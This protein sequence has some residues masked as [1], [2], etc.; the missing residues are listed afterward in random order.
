MT[1]WSIEFLSAVVSNF[2]NVFF[3]QLNE[4]APWFATGQLHL[5]RLIAPYLI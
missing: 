5:I 1:D 4:I 2:L 3:F